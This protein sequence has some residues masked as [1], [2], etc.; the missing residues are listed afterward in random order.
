MS[1]S[2]STP[3]KNIQI[4]ILGN[5][6][7]GKSSFIEAYI[8]SHF[9]QTNGKCSFGIQE[10]STLR[11]TDKLGEKLILELWDSY[12]EDYVG[13]RDMSIKY[14]DGF[15]IL[16]SIDDIDSFNDIKKYK[17]L[18]LRIQEINTIPILLIGNKLDKEKNRKVSKSLAEQYALEIGAGHLEVSTKKG[19]NIQI[20]VSE[21]IEMVIEYREKYGIKSL[22]N[23][24][25]TKFNLP[26]VFIRSLYT[27]TRKS[28]K[29]SFSQKN[30]QEIVKTSNNY[31]Y[32]PDEILILIFQNVPYSSISNLFLVSKRWNAIANDK[33]SL[34][35][36][37][38]KK[39]K[40]KHILSFF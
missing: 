16:Y 23:Q 32:L 20:G 27:N 31:I 5:E 37:Q 17:K 19:I 21:I 13:L 15:I 12:G 1:P 8:K 22:I 33:E 29:F 11:V 14:C 9:K 26:R 6:N 30:K 39:M 28:L 24:K 36:F 40:A 38:R 7:V 18:L 25:R 3:Q 4:M 35:Y 34:K 2:K 10:R